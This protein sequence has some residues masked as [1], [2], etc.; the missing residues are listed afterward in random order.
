MGFAPTK[1]PHAAERK[2]N[3]RRGWSEAEPTEQID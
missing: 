2:N 3:N 1:A